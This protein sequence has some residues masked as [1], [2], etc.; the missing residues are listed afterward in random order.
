MPPLVRWLALAQVQRA[1]LRA[2]AEKLAE[3]VGE[4]TRV[5]PHPPIAPHGDNT[6]K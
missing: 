3:A 5:E 4:P 2:E 1:L 6:S